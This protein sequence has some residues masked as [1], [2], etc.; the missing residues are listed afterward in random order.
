MIPVHVLT[1][2]ILK[3]VKMNDLLHFFVILRSYIPMLNV[4]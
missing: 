4:G 1:S 2:N 3:A